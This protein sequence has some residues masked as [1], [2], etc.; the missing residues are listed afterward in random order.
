MERLDNDVAFLAETVEMLGSEGRALLAQV[1]EAAASGDAPGLARSAHALK[2]MIS[3]FCAPSVHRVAMELEQ[4]G[5]AGGVSGAP[6][7]VDR[8]RERMESLITELGGF[9]RAR[10]Q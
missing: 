9:V 7:L 5:R 6:A 4:L 10:E 2:G 1:G 3:N 8:L